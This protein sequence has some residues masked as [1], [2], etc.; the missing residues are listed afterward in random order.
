V[1][2]CPTV[3]ETADDVS[4]TT[5]FNPPRVLRTAVLG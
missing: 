5:H 2:G 1:W 4:T 3:A